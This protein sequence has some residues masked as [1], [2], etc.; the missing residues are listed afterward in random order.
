MQDLNL[1]NS[2][3][4][5]ER[6]KVIYSFFIFSNVGQ[7]F[8]G[9]I[10]V[11]LLRNSLGTQTIFM[12]LA[13]LLFSV[14][15]GI[16][17]KIIFLKKVN[18]KR[19]I[20]NLNPDYWEK[21]F[22]FA[23]LIAAIAWGSAGYFLYPT[24]SLAN[25]TL[26]E[27]TIA[28]I[29]AASIATLAPSMRA[30]LIFIPLTILPLLI[31]IY[32][33][34]PENAAV[35]MGMII[36]Y[37]FI[38]LFSS[39]IFNQNTKENLSLR[40]AA[41]VRESELKESEEKYR[42][43]YEKS[44][45]P[46]MLFTGEKFAMVNKAALRAFGIATEE[47]FLNTPPFD[48][49]PKYQPDGVP[50]FKKAAK[51]MRKIAKEG[52]YRF[53][54]IYKHADGSTHPAD[55][56]MT[57]LPSKGKRAIFCVMRDIS[58]NKKIEQELILAQQ[59]ADD[60]NQAKSDFLAN[61]SH[62]IRTPMN[63]VI[64]T[65][66][67]LLRYP[68]SEE[69]KMRAMLIKNNADS[70]IKIINDILDFSKVE[71]GQLA[72]EIKEFNLDDLIKEFTSSIANRIKQKGIQFKLNLDDNL[73]N[74][75]KGD[76]G[77]IR[78][79]LTN[80]I[81]NAIKFTHDGL[82]SLSCQLV[83][84]GNNSSI[85]KFDIQ[86]TGVG[87][88]NDKQE[89]IFKR[90]N[91]GDESTTRKYGGTGLGLSICKQLCELMGGKISFSSQ[92]NKGTHFWFTLQLENIT[93]K[94]DLEKNYNL[95]IN[96]FEN[97]NATALIV[98]DNVTNQMV[99]K[100]ML[101]VFN[102]DITLVDDGMQAVEIL[103]KKK[104][105]IIFMDIHMPVMDGY[106]ATSTIRDPDSKVLDHK[107]V[108]IAMTASAMQGDKEKCLSFGMDD[109]IS[110][111]I[112]LNTLQVILHQWLPQKKRLKSKTQ[113]KEISQSKLTQSKHPIFDYQA[114]FNRLS[115]DKALIEKITQR[116]VASIRGYIKDI[117]QS[118]T[119]EDF[120][121]TRALAHKLKGSAATIGCM[122]LSHIAHKV[123]LAAKQE[124]GKELKKLLPLLFPEYEI[125]KRAIEAKI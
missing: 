3:I 118:Y 93:Q 90:F 104:F 29:I 39:R 61:M 26:L 81:D 12:W 84:E 88:S 22:L 72:L 37:L 48:F 15:F 94:N 60:A 7:L 124:E 43:L 106:Q 112:D 46:M 105:D 56:T 17:I 52:Y 69:Q 80:L 109:Y 117:Q 100:E 42:L 71:A 66:E 67:L 33:D 57:A 53:E 38:S 55:V 87:I 18:S 62:E 28:G 103:R 35:L 91:Q 41:D 120:E 6:L 31:R 30:I 25:Q 1:N 114:I 4:K 47:E 78:Q 77:R 10:L 49:S 45:D 111:P 16:V 86:D 11:Y 75:Y 24:Q 8:A 73:K 68:L 36:I 85:L 59:K 110:K 102:L 44:E 27:L 121:K 13:W 101:K 23:V 97:F 83:K 125:A 9:L 95:D 34:N 76:A 116:F 119:Q 89:K 50:S 99:A 58:E 98:D 19:S 96:T 123:E 14:V 82:I 2:K 70:M 108:I 79:I 63:G 64:G 5:I 115:G 21:L 74:W 122:R 32:Y 65:T 20:E 113:I 51:I 107:S 54:W 92:E 40:F